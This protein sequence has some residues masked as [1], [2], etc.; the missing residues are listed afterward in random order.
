[1]VLLISRS[2]T[3]GDL[4]AVAKEL[5]PTHRS[6]AIVGTAGTPLADM[7]PGAVMLEYAD[8]KS[9]M[10]TRFATT[11]LS[12]LR[13][14]LG[15]DVEAIARDGERAL[16]GELAVSGE[17]FDDLQHLVFLGDR[18]SAAL[19]Q[20]AALKVRE[21]AGMWTEAYPL[22]EYPHGPISCAGPTSL[23]WTFCE[24][25][26]WLASDIERTGAR[27][28]RGSLDP[29]AELVRVHRLAVELALREGRDP[30]APP[31]LNRSVLVTEV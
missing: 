26:A 31:Y 4:V 3:T 16:Q 25:P 28:E 7:V 10:Q 24:L 20:E 29:Q 21:A 19:A 30:D 14:T 17:A 13:H 1:V 12:L 6:V 2:G 9:V 23:I 22:S 11:A 27:I 8:E 18:W 5:G 15:D